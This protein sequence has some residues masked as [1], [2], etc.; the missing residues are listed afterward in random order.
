MNNY[1][2]QELKNLLKVKVLDEKYL[3][4]TSKEIDELIKELQKKEPIEVNDLS[5]TNAFD[6][7]LDD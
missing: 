7:Y 4:M 3:K 1:Q 5:T 2:K 6:R